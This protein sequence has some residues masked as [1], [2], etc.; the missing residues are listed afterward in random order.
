MTNEQ[1]CTLDGF[2]YRVNDL[3]AY[4]LFTAVI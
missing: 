1:C 2:Q 3:L 4:P